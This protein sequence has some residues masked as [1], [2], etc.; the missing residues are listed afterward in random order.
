MIAQM[1]EVIH[2]Y[3]DQL[4][5]SIVATDEEESNAIQVVPGRAV[6]VDAHTVEMTS[7][8]G[9]VRYL[10]GEHIL[11]ARDQRRLFPVS[12]V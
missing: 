8:D 1:D 12:Q 2:E 10:T 3:R 4:Y 5:A 9:T 6:L 11:I 7:F